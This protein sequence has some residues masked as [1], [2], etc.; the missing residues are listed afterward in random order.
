MI[1]KLIKLWFSLLFAREPVE[2]PQVDTPTPAEA[3][4]GIRVQGLRGLNDEDLHNLSIQF[5][6]PEYRPGD[7][8]EKWVLASG[9]QQV[10]RYLANNYRI[11]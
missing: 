9:H 4:D 2:A 5:A 6:M 10:I 3:E 7:T 11:N 8:I 1:W